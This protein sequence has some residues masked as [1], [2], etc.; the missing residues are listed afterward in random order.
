MTTFSNKDFITFPGEPI[1]GRVPTRT[2]VYGPAMNAFQFSGVAHAYKLFCDSYRL[3]A[4]GG[5]YHVQNRALADG[6]KIRMTSN[7]GV[8]TVKV[9]TGN[10]R[11]YLPLPLGIVIS[12]FKVD[13]VPNAD[14]YPFWEGGERI[15][16]CMRGEAPGPNEAD[17]RRQFDVI[18]QI[19][20]EA[21]LSE[22]S[23]KDGDVS[24]KLIPKGIVYGASGMYTID[25]NNE[26]TWSRSV[27]PWYANGFVSIGPYRFNFPNIKTAIDETNPLLKIVRFWTVGFPV[28]T[29]EFDPKKARGWL[30]F[31]VCIDDVTYKVFKRKVIGEL[32]PEIKSTDKDAELGCTEIATQ[33]LYDDI[34]RFRYDM[35]LTWS[36]DTFTLAPVGEMYTGEVFS[37]IS[38]TGDKTSV[39]ATL[40]LAPVYVPTNPSIPASTVE[41]LATGSNTSTPVWDTARIYTTSRSMTYSRTHYRLVQGAQNPWTLEW[42]TLPSVGAVTFSKTSSFS[43]GYGEIVVG[44]TGYEAVSLTWYIP[45]Q[46]STYPVSTAANTLTGTF[47]YAH[48]NLPAEYGFP[49]PV[50]SGTLPEGTPRLYHI[51][52]YTYTQTSET[53]EDLYTLDIPPVY[54]QTR[55]DI[56][57]TFSGGGTA[58]YLDTTMSWSVS[59]TLTSSGVRPEDNFTITASATGTSR[60]ITNQTTRASLGNY[61][62]E[63]L[64]PLNEDKSLGKI[65]GLFAK[66]N[67][68]V[69]FTENVS[70]A[71]TSM[72]TSLI[73]KMRDPLDDTPIPDVVIKADTFCSEFP[74]PLNFASGYSGITTGTSIT[75]DNPLFF[76]VG[77]GL[78]GSISGTTLSLAHSPGVPSAGETYLTTVDT[79]PG[80]LDSP[81]KDK[82]TYSVTGTKTTYTRAEFTAA[83]GLDD[84]IFE[85]Y[86]PTNGAG[87]T[88][89]SFYGPPSSD[90]SNVAIDKEWI[91]DFTP[92]F[93]NYEGHL[94]ADPRT[95]SFIAAFAGAGRTDGIGDVLLA[96]APLLRS[97]VGNKQGATPLEPL[98]NAW[99]EKTNEGRAKASPPLPPYPTY[100]PGELFIAWTDAVLGTSPLI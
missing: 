58:H 88:T 51:K 55:T 49:P 81:Q 8:D 70:A 61:N 39:T 67:W 56:T 15:D 65:A 62:G 83:F 25:K 82:A 43:A 44:F 17:T 64:I 19:D 16:A 5:G 4:G 89:V 73:V 90:N 42:T 35:H 57:G 59:E 11:G 96:G 45:P 85:Y 7:N 47:T 41:Y 3:S 91:S 94:Y 78:Q 100:Q 93:E 84:S 33:T 32:D 28:T 12:P 20:P 27:T 80:H 97:Y 76:N 77:W 53:S 29:T 52:S 18:V 79:P 50:Y 6:T 60:S 66:N 30:F 38:I 75:S 26:K 10:E 22:N 92:F 95:M 9:N 36:N 37:T 72:K 24:F 31:L 40:T 63:K 2:V 54:I 99:I 14:Y 48:P 1:T 98:I 68:S 87:V 69:V 13:E 46:T 23:F 86:F 74:T 34:A 21:T 71:N